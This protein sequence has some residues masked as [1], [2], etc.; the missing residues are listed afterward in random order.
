MWQLSWQTEKEMKTI[1]FDCNR[2]QDYIRS[3]T[4]ELKKI[5]KLAF[6]QNAFIKDITI[7]IHYIFMKSENEA[8]LKDFVRVN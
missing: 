5:K 6:L 3:T 1:K 7:D 2:L 8:S 4:K